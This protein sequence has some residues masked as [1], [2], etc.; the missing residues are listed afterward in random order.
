MCTN[1]QNEPIPKYDALIAKRVNIVT[2]NGVVHS[3]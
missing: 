2:F 1:F 3:C